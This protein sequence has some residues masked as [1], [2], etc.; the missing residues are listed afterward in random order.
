MK[1]KFSSS[2]EVNYKPVADFIE[3]GEELTK[4]EIIE[5]CSGNVPFDLLQSLKEIEFDKIGKENGELYLV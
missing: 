4:N 1:Y 5:K 3:E 2:L